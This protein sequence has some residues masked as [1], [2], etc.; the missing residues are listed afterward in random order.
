MGGEDAW[1]QQKLRVQRV[2]IVQEHFICCCRPGRL[3]NPAID[4]FNVQ[5]YRVNDRYLN[6]DAFKFYKEIY[7]LPDYDE[8]DHNMEFDI[9]TCAKIGP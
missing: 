8:A 2:N 5:I 3:M 7:G 9:I 1:I 4:V 6:A